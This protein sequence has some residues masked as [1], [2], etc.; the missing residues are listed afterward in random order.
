M[1]WKGSPVKVGCLSVTQYW[2]WAY[3]PV[4]FRL[5]TTYVHPLVT[6]RSNKTFPT[7]TSQHY[8]SYDDSSKCLLI[9]VFPKYWLMFII[10]GRIHSKFTFMKC[11]RKQNILFIVF[12]LIQNYRKQWLFQEKTQNLNMCLCKFSNSSEIK[13]PI[14]VYDIWE[15]ET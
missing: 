14:P 1:S 10:L 2:G 9:S 12:L 8:Y 11:L 6:L 13:Q 3:F 15:S 5:Q 4:N 7:V